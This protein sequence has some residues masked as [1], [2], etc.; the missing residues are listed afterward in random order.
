M[1]DLRIP[2]ERHRLENGLDVVLSPDATMPIVAVN[3]W[4]AV[5]SRNEEPGRTG[6]AHLFEHMMFQGSLHVPKNGHFEFIERA[7]GS[8]N[9]ST[10]FDRTNY[11]ET[12]PAHQLDLGLWLEADRMG[13]MLPAM[14]QEKLDNQ[15]DVVRNEKLQSYDNRPYGDWSERV[16]AM[17]FPP[18]HPYYHTVIGSME[19]LD[20]ATLQDVAGFFEAYYVP[21]NCVLTVCGDVEPGEALARV[22]HFF[23]EI[24]AGGPI[25]PIPGSTEIDAIIGETLRERVTSKVP[26]ARTMVAS[27]IPPYAEPDFYTADV[28]STVLGSGRASR[29]YRSLVREQRIAKDAGSFAYPLVG[30]TSMLLAWATGYPDADLD[31]LE[32]ALLGELDG[33]ASVDSGEVGRAV[34]L[35]ETAM[36]RSIEEVGERADLLSRFATFF[37]DPE[38]LNTEMER[39]RAVTPERVGSFSTEMLGS[40]NRAVLTFVPEEAS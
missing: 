28:A 12:L 8:M 29:L 15:R 31:A 9:G 25:P 35:S 18:D 4:Y 19:D 10:W 13:W 21:N 30:G 39:I 36:V 32:A 5:G 27:R 14:T 11:Y 34:A 20:A 22:R 24:P 2:V 1:S 33:L 16:Q 38:L 40:A 26:L 3:L 17:V 7:G 6:F 23:D 37:D